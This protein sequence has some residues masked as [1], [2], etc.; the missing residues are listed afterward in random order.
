ML[1]M[2]CQT[3]VSKFVELE[4]LTI[5]NFLNGS[6]SSLTSYSAKRAEF[7]PPPLFAGRSGQTAIHHHHILHGSHRLPNET[8]P[9]G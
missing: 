6:P 8:Q 9:S 4:S 3:E 5:I 2:G 7:T 1:H